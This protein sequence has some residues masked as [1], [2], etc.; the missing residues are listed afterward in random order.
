MGKIEYFNIKCDCSK[1][2]CPVF[3][4]CCF[5]PT[6][7]HPDPEGEISILFVGQGG[8]ADERK[9]GRPFIGRAG[10]RL[11]NQIVSWRQSLRKHV[12]VAF[13]NTI[14]DNPDNNRVPTKEE[15]EYCLEYLYKDISTLKDK[16]LKVV[17]PLGNAAKKALLPNSGS[18]GADHGTLFELKNKKFGE[19]SV[20]PTYH[21]SYVIRNVP[22]FNA[23]KLS[24]LDLTVIADMYTAYRICVSKKSEKCLDIDSELEISI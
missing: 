12:G 24:E 9:K 6:E 18:M 16:G 5:L 10:Q 2:E 8:G 23:E 7:C 13:S 15:F 14:R 3:N 20:I 4:K 19:I 21:P 1:S 22:K 17:V 11:R